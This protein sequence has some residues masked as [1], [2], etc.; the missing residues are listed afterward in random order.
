MNEGVEVAA[1]THQVASQKPREVQPT[2]RLGVEMGVL[3]PFL[4]P[5]RQLGRLGCVCA[6]SARAPAGPYPVGLRPTVK[7]KRA[8]SPKVRVRHLR[9]KPVVPAFRAGRGLG[10]KRA[11]AAGGLLS[12]SRHSNQSLASTFV[13]GLP[14]MP[15]PVSIVPE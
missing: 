5:R 12:V 1:R 4:N 8:R 6:G 2:L 14:S 10:R 3:L 7:Y 11:V 13:D 9:P 15:E